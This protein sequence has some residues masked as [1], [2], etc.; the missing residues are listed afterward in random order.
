MFVQNSVRHVWPECV[1]PLRQHWRTNE[2]KLRAHRGRGAGRLQWRRWR[3]RRRRRRGRRRRRRRRRRRL[4]CARGWRGR[5]RRLLRLRRGGRRRGRRLRLL[6]TRC[7]RGRRLRLLS[8]RCGRGRRLRLLCARRGR[9][10]RGRSGFPGGCNS[11]RGFPEDGQPG[12][13]LRGQVRFLHTPPSPP[14]A[15][16]VAALKEPALALGNEEAEHDDAASLV[17]PFWCWGQ[18]GFFGVG[19]W[20]SGFALLFCF[21]GWAIFGWLGEDVLVLGSDFCVGVG[22]DFCIGV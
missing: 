12:L 11:R 2:A 14:A 3:R 13:D 21:L 22:L 15:P 7:G 8:T 6:S 17:L 18:S 9:G 16:P 20:T 5:G 10:G 1:A 4:L 19:G